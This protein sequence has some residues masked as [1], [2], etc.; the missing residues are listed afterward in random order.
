MILGTIIYTFLEMF[1][2][3]LVSGSV[4]IAK[5]ILTN[6]VTYFTRDQNIF[7]SFCKL[8]FFQNTSIWMGIIKGIAYGIVALFLFIGIVKSIT[9]TFTGENAENPLQAT[10]R[11]LLTV[12]MI[13]LIFGF[14]FGNAGVFKFSGVLGMISKLFGTIL[15]YVPAYTESLNISFDIW[16]TDVANYLGLVILYG[17]LMVSVLG[18][19]LTYVERIISFAV[20]IMVGPI[21]VAFNA[22]RDTAETCKN[23]LI[24]IFSHFL[25]ILISLVFWWSFLQSLNAAFKV[26]DSSQLFMLAISIALL[27]IVRNSEKILNAIGLKT[28]ANREA[29]SALIGGIGALGTGMMM[30]MR[31]GSSFKGVGK[32]QSGTSAVGGGQSLYNNGSLMS[33]VSFRNSQ[34][35]MTFGSVAKGLQQSVSNMVAANGGVWST[36]TAANP[37]K[38]QGSYR[39]V[40][41]F[42]EK[43]AQAA[44]DLLKA[45]AN[46]NSV[47][48]KDINKAFGIGKTSQVKAVEGGEFKYASASSIAGNNVE[49]YIGPAT[50][51]HGGKVDTMD[52][53]FFVTNGSNETLAPGTA[54]GDGRY[55][56]S[57]SPI[58][59]GSGNRIYQTVAPEQ[60]KTVNVAGFETT[61]SSGNTTYQSL[62]SILENSSGRYNEPP[63]Q[64][65][66]NDI[67]QPQ[68]NTVIG[69]ENI[70]NTYNDEDSVNIMN[71]TFARSVRDNNYS[72]QP[73]KSKDHNNSKSKHKDLPFGDH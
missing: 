34:G 59:D 49:G 10:L 28:I 3:L 26:E 67:P 30:A 36:I 55:I 22:Y 63:I 47:T 27:G 20:Y 42:G 8:I 25:A 66:G 29:A 51:A 23:W 39:D 24:G 65:A 5:L 64:S 61:D 16:H 6:T 17:T 31:I 9:S 15:S 53:A 72:K 62:D 32:G 57:S 12:I 13:G 2:Q 69:S 73:S 33:S 21:A 44:D 45:A 71:K 4:Y 43:R 52:N 48:G 58:I 70:G 41:V 56:G 50:Y 7:E 46:G 18:A 54:V 11:A 1:M 19:A 40:G 37:F 60:P 35:K 38:G 68:A 14:D